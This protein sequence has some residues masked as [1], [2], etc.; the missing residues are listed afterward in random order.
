MNDPPPLLD[1]A[2][3]ARQRKRLLHS[4]AKLLNALQAHESERTRLQLESQGQALEEEETAQDQMLLDDG[5]VLADQ[6]AKR[7]I[8]IDRALAKIDD[9]SYGF[10]D[11][12]G[13]PIPLKRLEAEPEAITVG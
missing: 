5:R 9:G 4:R 1:D 8:P 10:S 13:E 3:I 11:V 7:L 6:L 12:T 2:F